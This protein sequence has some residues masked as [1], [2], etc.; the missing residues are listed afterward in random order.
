MVACP[1]FDY[2]ALGL[3]EC[4]E[5]FFDVRMQAGRLIFTEVMAEYNAFAFKVFATV[6]RPEAIAWNVYDLRPL[7]IPIDHCTEIELN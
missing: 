3:V 7:I 1:G 5:I 2:L 6:T 4:P